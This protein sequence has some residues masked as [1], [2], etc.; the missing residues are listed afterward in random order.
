M[1]LGTNV[2]AHLGLLDSGYLENMVKQDWNL[3]PFSVQISVH[4]KKIPP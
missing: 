3:T 1:M 2:R 4:N